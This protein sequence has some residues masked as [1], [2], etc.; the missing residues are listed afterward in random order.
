VKIETAASSAPRTAARRLSAGAEVVPEG[1]RF[2]VWA[3]ARRHVDVRVETGAPGLHP[4]APERDGWFSGLVPGLCSGARYRY[5]LDEADAFPDP[6]SRFQ[7]EGPH[8][9]SEVVDPSRFGW[10]DASWPGLRPDGQV[11]YE[12][13]VGTFTA[14]GTLEAAARE[15]HALVALGVTAVELLPVAEFAGRFGWGYDGVDLYAPSHLYGEPDDLRR[16]VDRAHALGLGVLLDVVYN[17]CGP[18]GC[19]LKEFAP[20][21]FSARYDGEW[22]E[23]F[24]FDGEGSAAVRA[25][26][27]ENAAYWISEF[28]LD[29][30][31]VDATQGMFDA[32]ARHVL[33][34]LSERCR[35]AAGDRSIL[36]VAEN[37]PQD[38]AIVRPVEDGGRGFDMIWND[39]L[40]HSAVVALVGRRE[41]YYSDHRGTPQELLSAVKHGFLFQGQRY[42]W[43]GKRRGTSTR[44]LPPRAFVAFLEN[45]DQV[46]NSPHGER[47][48]T[49][50]SPGR[51]RAMTALLLLAPWTPMLFQGVER[52]ATQP[53]LYFADHG[54][55]LSR[56]V[57]AGRAAFERQF[58]SAAGRDM[59]DRLADPSA[60]ETFARCKLG[61]A[62]SPASRAALALH[63][64]L[65]ELRRTDP[66]LRDRDAA[67]MDGAV[68][69]AEALCL[70]WAGAEGRDRLLLVNLGP[71]LDLGS[72]AEPLIASPDRAGWRIAWSSEDPRYGGGGTPELDDERGVQLPGHAAL[73]LAPGAAVA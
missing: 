20:E 73:L 21:Y 4:L 64:D 55:E 53:F 47:L 22:G 71:D 12:L 25:F 19:Y 35:D 42:A 63:R 8:G 23:P 3:P 60:P 66:V 34:D 5:R 39:D 41:A 72:V 15:L 59:R 1:V 24:N 54:G 2:R 10:T 27:V 13:H 69:G 49:R 70:R 31:R 57:R 68:L 50:T 38:A 26:V 61:G 44:G 18:D 17:H 62:G 67:G 33:C 36:L 16:F 48:R 11:L 6:S 65:L 14:E 32:S 37:E 45:H 9:P 56:A 58:P 30:L 46:A 51:W 28:H 52:A 7:P 43:Q 40:H 29:G